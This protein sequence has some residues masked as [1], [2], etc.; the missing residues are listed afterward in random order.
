MPFS[1]CRYG[2]LRCPSE[3]VLLQWEH[4][5]WATSRILVHSPK[6]EHHPNGTTR[7]VPLFPELRGLL[8]DAFEI[9]EGGVVFVLS[10]Y[11]S[12][13]KNFRTRLL[14]ISKRAGLKPWP[15]LFQN[16]RSTR[17]TELEEEFPTPANPRYESTRHTKSSKRA[18]RPQRQAKE[19]KKEERDFWLAGGNR[20]KYCLHPRCFRLL[21][22]EGG[23]SQHVLSFTPDPGRRVASTKVLRRP[24]A[25]QRNVPKK[26]P[27][28]QP[29]D[30]L[31]MTSP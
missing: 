9:A 20:K 14:K 3:L 28:M 16:L 2:G 23:S 5:D 29:R 26:R 21:W 1:L 30:A 24:T 10:S 25:S 27:S 17:Q 13:S 15:K 22:A 19:I 12:P 4:I 31:G 8:R 7:I 18:E 11:R 6:T